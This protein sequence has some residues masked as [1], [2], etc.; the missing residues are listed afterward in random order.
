MIDPRYFGKSLLS[1][2]VALAAA[3]FL[4]GSFGL[5]TAF[6]V[7]SK[8]VAS[9]S[10]PVANE[11][12]PPAPARSPITPDTR[13]IAD[14]CAENVTERRS[15]VVFRGG[16]CVVVDEPSTDPVADAR[17]RLAACDEPDARFVPELTREGNLI[18]SFKEPVFL[19]FTAEELSELA[20]EIDH[21]APALLTPKE[22]VA[23]GTEWVPPTHAKFGL[24]ARRRMLEDAASPVPVRIIR[25]KQRVTAKN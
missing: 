13:T 7:P 24:L 21:L 19:N 25:A 17:K 18:I 8:P 10:S 16:T 9:R 3:L 12:P 1:S 22:R 5:G 2:R 4:A 15:F 6:L 20:S 14:F 11:T 23:A